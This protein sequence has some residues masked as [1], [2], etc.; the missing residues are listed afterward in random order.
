MTLLFQGEDYSTLT[1]S[2]RMPNSNRYR[3]LFL[4]AWRSQRSGR[5]ALILLSTSPNSRKDV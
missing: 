5:A 2:V 3:Y 1:F 4:S